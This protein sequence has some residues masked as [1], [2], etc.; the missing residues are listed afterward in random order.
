MERIQ[1]Q[2]YR[3]GVFEQLDGVPEDHGLKAAG[4]FSF[5]RDG[6]RWTIFMTETE[7]VPQSVKSQGVRA[8]A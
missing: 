5:M 6:V 1:T 4:S 7:S 2:C 8:I 3:D